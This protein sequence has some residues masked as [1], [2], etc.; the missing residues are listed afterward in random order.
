MW[1]A[2]D[3]AGLKLFR[4]KPFRGKKGFWES[5]DGN[6][7]MYIDKTLFPEVERIDSGGEIMEVELIKK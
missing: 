1:I 4:E 3:F 5:G 6:G 2:R 7:W